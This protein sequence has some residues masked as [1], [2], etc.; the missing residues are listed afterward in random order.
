MLQNIRSKNAIYT[1]FIVRE[2]SDVTDNI[3]IAFCPR[4]NINVT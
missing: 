3:W 2:S 4:I 1:F